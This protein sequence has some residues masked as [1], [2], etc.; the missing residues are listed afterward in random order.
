MDLLGRHPTCRQRSDATAHAIADTSPRCTHRLAGTPQTRPQHLRQGLLLL[1]LRHLRRLDLDGGLGLRAARHGRHDVGRAAAPPP[2]E[3][4]GAPLLPLAAAHTP[5][6][7]RRSAADRRRRAGPA[8]PFRGAGIFAAGPMQRRHVRVEVVDQNE[9]PPAGLARAA[10]AARCRGNAG[11]VRN[12]AGVRRRPGLAQEGRDARHAGGVGRVERRPGLGIEQVVGPAVEGVV[13]RRVDVAPGHAVPPPDA[14]LDVI[15]PDLGG[16]A[17]LDPVV[18]VVLVV[19]GLGPVVQDQR[20]RRR[21]I[22]RRLRRYC[23][24]RGVLIEQMFQFRHVEPPA[25]G[26]DED[27]IPRGIDGRRHGVTRGGGGGCGS[28]T[29][30]NIDERRRPGRGHRPARRRRPRH[31]RG[32]VHAR[33][34]P[35]FGFA[36]PTP[37]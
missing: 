11:V 26:R 32:S 19:A 35:R 29:R 25:H 9:A 2:G 13:G 3:G 7:D 37:T 15:L 22:R 34:D 33:A 24:R 18:S 16:V 1:E 27:G 5:G 21:R 31:E 36:I 17:L 10:A 14:E 23:E 4:A 6:S 12:D 28:T 30:D 20:A 8:S